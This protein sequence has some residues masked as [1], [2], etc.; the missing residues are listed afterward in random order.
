MK[1]QGIN[2]LI[3]CDKLSG[4]TKNCDLLR[5]FPF[6]YW[7]HSPDFSL[8]CTALRPITITYSVRCNRETYYACYYVDKTHTQKIAISLIFDVIIPLEFNV[9]EPRVE[10]GAVIYLGDFLFGSRKR[11]A[12]LIWNNSLAYSLDCTSLSPITITY[13]FHFYYYY[14]YYYYYY[15][16]YYYYYHYYI[17]Q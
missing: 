1:W 6:L 11:S 15:H 17:Y 8:N 12:R 7:N 13:Y 14:H 3:L 16:Y 5:G 4:R 2:R 10:R 9:D